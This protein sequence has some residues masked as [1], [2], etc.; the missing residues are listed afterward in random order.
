MAGKC[1]A[2]VAAVTG[3]SRGIGRAIAEELLAEGASVAIC[4]R[5]EEKGKAALD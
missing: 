4:G 5:S 1:E 2:R 3:G